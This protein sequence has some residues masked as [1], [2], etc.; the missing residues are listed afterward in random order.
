MM[1]GLRMAEGIREDRFASL[2]GI[3]LQQA[4]GNKL[5]QFVRDGFLLWEDGVLR[6]TRKGMD[7]QNQVLVDLMP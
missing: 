1:L 4:Y 7:F 2:H 3:S 6:L 5:E